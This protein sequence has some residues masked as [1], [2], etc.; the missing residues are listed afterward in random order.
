MQPRQPVASAMQAQALSR[1][2][3]TR[4]QSRSIHVTTVSYHE[5]MTE[6][7]VCAG[8]PFMCVQEWCRS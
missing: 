5:A 8:Y 7:I 2:P 1:W 4:E 6:A 3:A